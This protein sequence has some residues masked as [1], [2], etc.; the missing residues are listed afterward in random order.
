M[1][2]FLKRRQRKQPPQSKK[3]Q[4][5]SRSKQPVGQPNQTTQPKSHLHARKA[6]SERP[7]RPQHRRTS[8]TPAD[9]TLK[10]L[11]QK[12]QQL[13]KALEKLSDPQAGFQNRVT[14]QNLHMKEPV[15]K[16]LAFEMDQLKLDE[17]SGA[18]NLGNNFGVEVGQKPKKKQ[19]QSQRQ[20]RSSDSEGNEYAG[21]K[22]TSD[23]FRFHFGED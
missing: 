10:E 8:T 1:F 16:E 2:H 7:K 19:S 4:T 15:L 3:S 9:Q 20:K 17:V 12:I 18:L 22:K 13:E 6:A 5:P 14:I 11:S 21:F 23:G